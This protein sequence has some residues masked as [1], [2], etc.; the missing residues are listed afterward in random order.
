MEML[1]MLT[2]ADGVTLA[3]A[4]CGLLSIMFAVSGNFNVAAWMIIA[5][6][7]FDW[8]DGKVAQLRKESHDLGKELDSLADIISFGIAPAIFGFLLIKWHPV[9]TIV[10]LFFLL[11]GVLR[12]ARFNITNCKGY[13]EGVPIT[14]NGILFP[15]IYWTGVPIEFY[16]YIYFFMGVLMISTWK[17]KKVI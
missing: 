13:Y 8:A 2:V 16:V 14:V 3:N 17:V 12:L 1:K 15:L 10:I 4:A 6:M 9:I 7:V 11:C 5:A